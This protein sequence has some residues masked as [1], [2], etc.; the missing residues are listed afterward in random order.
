MN[1]KELIETISANTGSSKNQTEKMLQALI[2]VIRLE[3]FQKGNNMALYGLGTF[4]Q[5]ITNAKTGRN[6]KTGDALHIPARTKLVF[7]ATAELRGK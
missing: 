1:K 4:K 3:T 6:P 5:K 7:T 2:N